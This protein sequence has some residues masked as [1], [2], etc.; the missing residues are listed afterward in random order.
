MTKTNQSE[1]N[2]LVSEANALVS[3]ANAL[4]SEVILCPP[5]RFVDARTVKSMKQDRGTLRLQIKT[6]PDSQLVG[7]VMLKMRDIN[8]GAQDQG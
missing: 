1:V 2:A 8:T 3:E 4:V 7:V 5:D 6:Y